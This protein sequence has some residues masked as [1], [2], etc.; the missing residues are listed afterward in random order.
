VPLTPVDIVSHA[1]RNKLY[2]GARQESLA[3]IDGAADSVLRLMPVPAGMTDLLLDGDRLYCASGG[4]S[5]VLVVD[6]AADSLIGIIELPDAPVGLA[7]D[8]VRQKLYCAG[9]FPHMVTVVDL[10]G[11]G[12]VTAVPVPMPQALALD[13]ARAR[14]YV[15]TQDTTLIVIDCAGDSV[16]AV[17][18]VGADCPELALAQGTLI[19]PSRTRGAVSLVRDDS[20]AGRTLVSSAGPRAAVRAAGKLYVALELADELAVYALP[21]LEL[22]RTIPVP[23]Q[24]WALVWDEPRQKVYCACAGADRVLAVDA[25][26]D[27]LL[28]LVPVGRAPRTLCLDPAGDKLY[29]G[30]FGSTELFVVDCNAD[31]VLGTVV[32]GR[33]TRRLVYSPTSRK[34]YVCCH[35]SR[36][37]VAVDCRS[38]SVLARF[39]TGGNP[40]LAVFDR[41]DDYIYTG[42][43][44]GGPVIS[45]PGDTLVGSIGDAFY[46]KGGCYDGSTNRVYLGRSY[47]GDVLVIDG[48]ARQVIDHITVPDY[49]AEMGLTATGRIYI[50]H[51]FN[52]RPTTDLSVV[53]G[54][55]LEAVLRVRPSPVDLLVDDADARVYVLNWESSC[56]TVVDDMAGAVEEA[57]SAEARPPN[58][59]ATVVRGLLRVGDGR[60]NAGCRAELRD[61][62]G[63]RVMALVPGDNDVSRLAAGVYMA[64]VR[65][66]TGVRVVVAR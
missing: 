6:C 39:P 14:L 34:V 28:A 47:S 24:P 46:V 38:D 60:L 5:S 57:P 40:W 9:R 52:N 37:V 58:R 42:T 16:V 62:C 12:I 31:T 18:A 55:T 63:R 30:C 29:C 33:A 27:S 13:T 15:G 25:R 21:G 4:D 23:S 41:Q 51:A 7:I 53:S 26:T 59:G 8:R 20:V 61:V 48:S 56:I 19:A 2:V 65:P 54:D 3:V 66:G 17:L 22:L 36:E 45:C 49:P 35:D 50:G 44:W 1:G 43:S 64:T 10:A 11:G 32:T